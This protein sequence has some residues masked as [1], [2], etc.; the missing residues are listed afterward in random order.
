MA[1]YVALHRPRDT[2]LAMH[3]AGLYLPC[4][5]CLDALGSFTKP[6][7][8]CGP[9]VSWLRVVPELLFDR[10]L[11]ASSFAALACQ[12]SPDGHSRQARH[13]DA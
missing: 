3:S 4:S 1:A 12:P 13:S 11:A 8:I 2:W 6:R 7:P 9:R 5:P 10:R